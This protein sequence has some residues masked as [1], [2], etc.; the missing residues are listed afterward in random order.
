[1]RFF[2]GD[3]RK[4]VEKILLW[5]RRG[6]VVVRFCCGVSVFMVLVLNGVSLLGEWGILR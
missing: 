4:P 3:F 5:S 2:Y 1:M 6:R